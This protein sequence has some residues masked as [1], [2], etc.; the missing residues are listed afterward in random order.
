MGLICISE[1][2]KTIDDSESDY[3]EGEAED[4]PKVSNIFETTKLLPKSGNL[5]C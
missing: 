1:E 3:G 2:E 4:I 5:N